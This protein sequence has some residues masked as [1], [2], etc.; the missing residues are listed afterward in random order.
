MKKYLYV[1]VICILL[2]IITFVI[3]NARG[4]RQESVVS[5]LPFKVVMILPGPITDGSWS[6]S[7]YEA[8]VRIKDEFKIATQYHQNVQVQDIE[9]LV[10]AYAKEKSVFIIGFGGEYSAALEQ[11]AIRY[12][13]MEFALV[14]N[15][16]GNG[17]NYG[18]LSTKRGAFHLAG[19]FAALN[20]KSNVIGIITGEDLTHTRA[21]NAS[22]EQGV[23][24]IN[25]EIRVLNQYVGSWNN[26]L[27]S[28]RV[29]KDLIGSNVDILVVNVDHANDDIHKYATDMNIKTIS[30][31]TNSK[32]K[33]PNTVIG[34]IVIDNYNLLRYGV[35]LYLQGKWEGKIYNLGLVEG[36]M[37]FDININKLNTQQRQTYKDVYKRLIQKRI[38]NLSRVD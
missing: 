25:P 7:G 34:S 9:S 17:K 32:E 31:V 8:L 26:K 35:D 5:E 6:Q 27:E 18:C 21:E 11:E 30:V 2:I 15:Y 4:D 19:V 12:P 16:P 33:F 3:V 38:T 1:F 28:L 23:Q 36:V 10:S 20:T 37:F 13:Q 29:A 14:G 22:L 24:D